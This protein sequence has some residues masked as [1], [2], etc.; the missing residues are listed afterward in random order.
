MPLDIEYEDF[1]FR[2]FMR[3]YSA[4]TEEKRAAILGFFHLVEA[5]AASALV[6]LRIQRS[7]RVKL[8]LEVSTIED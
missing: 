3:F 4:Q 8:V 2:S 7:G 1:T 6:H 5:E